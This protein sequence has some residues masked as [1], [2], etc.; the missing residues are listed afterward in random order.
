MAKIA[1]AGHCPFFAAAAPTVMNMDSWQELANPRDLTKIFGSPEYAPWQL[2]A[3]SDDARYLGLTMPRY[4]AR[5][6]YGSKTDPVEAFAFEEDAEGG[7]HQPVR[8]DRTLPTPWAS[9][10][11]ARSSSTAGAPRSAA[12][13]AAA[14]SKVCPATPSRPTTAAWT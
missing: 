7:S 6:P 4:L 12:R 11:P 8:L 13:R 14:W 2:V 3:R 5:L 1:A 10:W 9:T